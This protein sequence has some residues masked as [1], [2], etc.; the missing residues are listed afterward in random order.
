MRGGLTRRVMVAS[1]ALV[2]L[3]AGAF[4]VLLVA[5][6][7][8]RDSA[9]LAR[10]SRME[11]AAANRLEKLVVDLETGQRGFVITGEQRFLAPWR[12]ARRTC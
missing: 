11:L 5:V 10:H 1:T 3:I 8:T 6:D 12:V 9:A 2:V 7:R 4:G